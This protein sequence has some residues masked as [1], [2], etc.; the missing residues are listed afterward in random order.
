MTI[1]SIFRQVEGEE[2]KPFQNLLRESCH[3]DRDCDNRDG[4]AAPYCRHQCS[5]MA[6]VIAGAEHTVYLQ[7]CLKAASSRVYFSRLREYGQHFYSMYSCLL[8]NWTRYCLVSFQM[9]NFKYINKVA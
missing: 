2:K 9:V 4:D 1:C 3:C 6:S 8:L 5:C 7:S